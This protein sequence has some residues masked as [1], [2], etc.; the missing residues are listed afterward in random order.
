MVTVVSF[1]RGVNVGGYHKIRME[2][3]RKV[4]EALGLEDVKTLLQSGNVV[5]RTRERNLQKLA[6]RIEA[7]IEER[8][9]FRPAVILRTAAE[10]AE[11][12]ARNPFAGRKDVEPAKLAVVFLGSD[13]G[14]EVREAVRRIP[15]DPEELRIE[16]RE[17][18]IYFPNGMGRPRL[19]MPVVERTLKVAA[20]ARNWNT[21]RKLGELAGSMVDGR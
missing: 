16:G 12:M 18:Y 8:W 15:C 10:M 11:A 9:G 6:G 1:L 3:L 7:A 19:S 20:T 2:E 5:F 17:M 13:P 14:E 21:V 4:Y